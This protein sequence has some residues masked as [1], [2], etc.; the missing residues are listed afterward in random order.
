MDASFNNNGWKIADITTERQGEK[1]KQQQ[2]ANKL[3]EH[4]AK[5]FKPA[6]VGDAVNFMMPLDLF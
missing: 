3:V 4:S 2:Q 6:E 5:R 1:R